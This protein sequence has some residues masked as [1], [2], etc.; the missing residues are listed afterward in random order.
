MVL[1][2]AYFCF[3][4]LFIEL[5]YLDFGVKYYLDLNLYC[6]YISNNASFLVFSP[7]EV[8]VGPEAQPQKIRAWGPGLE[9]GVVGK[10]GDFVAEFIGTDVGVL[11]EITESSDQTRGTFIIQ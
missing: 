1:K 9:G 2:L 10:S 6:T 8:Q 4:K 7:F 5:I 11:G 3:T